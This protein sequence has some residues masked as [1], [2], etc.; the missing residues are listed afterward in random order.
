MPDSIAIHPFLSIQAPNGPRA[1]AMSFTSSPQPLLGTS[2]S[3]HT[4]DIRHHGIS[5]LEPHSGMAEDNTELHKMAQITEDEDFD[6]RR[7]PY[8]QVSIFDHN[9]QESWD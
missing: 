8:L 5:H 9:Q 7:P 2:D 3:T 6:M 1:P 4:D